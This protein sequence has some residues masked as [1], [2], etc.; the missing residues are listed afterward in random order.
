MSKENMK[1]GPIA[2]MAKNSVAANILMIF[3]LAGGLFMGFNIKQEVFPDFEIDVVNISVA[4]PGA[5]PDEVEKGVILPVEEA[6]EGINGI[7]KIRSTA[8][9]S[10]GTVTVEAVTGYDMQKLYQDIKNEV[11]RIDSFPD[12]AED[13]QVMIPSTRWRVVSI[14]LS[15][16]QSYHTL[17]NYADVVKNRLVA[18]KN[19][20]VVEISSKRDYEIKVSVSEEQLKKYNLTLQQIASKINSSALDLPAGTIE[21]AQG[22]ILIRVKERKDYGPQFS[23]IPVI[24]DKSGAAVR[25]GDIATIE[26]GFEETVNYMNFNGKSALELEIFRVGNQKPVDVANAVKSEL[27]KLNEILPAGLS[28]KVV[29]DRSEIFNQRMH[30]LLKNGLMGLILVMILLSLFLE[31][32]LA[33][34]VT[35]GILIS[36]MGALLLMPLFNVSINM[37]SLFAFIITLGIVVD[38][39]IVV[40]E[41]IY[42]YRQKGMHFIEASIKGA[43]EISAPVVFSIMTNIVA[44]MPMYFIPGVA[45]K[46]FRII[47]LVVASV[48][49]ISL[50]EALFILPAHLGHQKNYFVSRIMYFIHRQQQKI[51]HFLE[52]MIENLYRPFLKSTLK[53]RYVSIVAGV[54]ILLITIA[55]IASGRMGFSMFPKVQSDFARLKV[56][57]PIGESDAKI[58][59]TAEK[60]STSAEKLREKY[61][62]SGLVENILV[63]VS[64]NSITIRVFLAPPEKRI[65]STSDFVKEWRK[66][67]GSI[68]GAEQINFSSDFGGPGSGADLTVELSHSNMDVLKSASS[69]LASELEKFEI[70]SDIEDGFL[71]GKDQ[72]DVKLKPKAY[73]L[74]FSPEVMAR[75]LRSRYYGAEALKQLRGKNEVSVMVRLN[76]QQRNSVSFFEDMKIQSPNGV[77]V[78]LN[79]VAVIERGKA[80]TSIQR[81]DGKRVVTVTASVTPQ[82]RTGEITKSLEKNVLPGLMSNYPG[83][84][85]SFE[86]EQSDLR[87]SVGTLVKGLGVALLAIYVLLAVPFKSYLQPIIIMCSIPFGII[88]AVYGHLLLGYSLSLMSLFGIVA[89]AGVVVNS[90]LVLIDFANRLRRDSG[91]NSYS[92]ILESSMSRF[93]PVLLTTLTTFFGL[94]PMVFEKS[95][96]A[97][98]LIPMAIS[99]AFGILF[100]VF[101]TLI[102]VPSLYVILEDVKDFFTKILG[103]RK[104]YGESK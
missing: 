47:P 20:T 35:M 69:K 67:L 82:S 74:G 18:N 83:L 54:A 78:A 39:A 53:F 99:L 28:L 84:S 34:W 81:R 8:N 97:K 96:Q 22:D 71:E 46:I 1:K 43:R 41:N 100:G 16:N 21:S 58:R 14:V 57:M 11:D 12:E 92:A 51:S 45:G 87:E 10:S 50:V 72:F 95:M 93:R 52:W 33:F 66:E 70:T 15:G 38:D 29:N 98:F 5:S 89:L 42:T 44:F 80:Y 102:F 37:I 48:F 63:N 75:E 55:F 9:E 77:N 2:W 31:I 88:G 65:I 40:G 30:L 59:Q 60:I 4:Y 56:Q 79:D 94:M 61:S 13:P 32:R 26:D 91:Y 68:Q 27:K 73:F 49:L 90:A 103:S 36:F 23:R 3:I 64:G 6:I 76:E 85:Y 7:K 101:I 25:L 17:R 24:N 104:H 19:I 62:Q 86:G